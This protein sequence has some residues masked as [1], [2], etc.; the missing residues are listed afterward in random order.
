M[1]GF[2]YFEDPARVSARWLPSLQIQNPVYNVIS[3]GVQVGI[4]SILRYPSA[5]QVVDVKFFGDLPI[6]R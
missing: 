6:F 1:K 4:V 5:N 2:F 3:L